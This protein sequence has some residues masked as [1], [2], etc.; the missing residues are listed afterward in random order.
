MKLTLEISE[1]EELTKA[2]KPEFKDQDR[3]KITFSK[4]RV[5]IVATDITAMQATFNTLAKLIK[6]YDKTRE[7]KNGF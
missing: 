3:S 4:G 5:E 6:V 1:D 2:I 7:L